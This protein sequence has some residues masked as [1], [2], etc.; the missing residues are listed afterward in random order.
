MNGIIYLGP[1]PITKGTD[2]FKDTKGGIYRKVRGERKFE[3]VEKMSPGKT[4][5]AYSTRKNMGKAARRYV[6]KNDLCVND[7]IKL[8]K[9]AKRCGYGNGLKDIF[10]GYELQNVLR[11]VKWNTDGK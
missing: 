9:A 1:D 2:L 5:V 3:L 10:L 4:P 7:A 11:S 8:D 6:E